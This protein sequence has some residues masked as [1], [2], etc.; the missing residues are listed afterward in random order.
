M[1]N[2]KE[3]TINGKQKEI[4]KGSLSLMITLSK[5]KIVMED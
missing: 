2:S 1:I 4:V 3:V 5:S